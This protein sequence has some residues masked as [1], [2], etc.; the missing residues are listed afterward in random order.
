MEAT[1]KCKLTAPRVRGTGSVQRDA[2][3][4]PPVQP[5]VCGEQKMRS[6]DLVTRLGS[7][8]RVRGTAKAQTRY[9]VTVTVQPR[10]C[11]EQASVWGIRQF[12]FGSAPRVRG[13]VTPVNERIA[14][15]RFSPACA[16]NST[17]QPRKTV[18]K[19]VQPRV[20]G[21]QCPSPALREAVIGSAPRVRGTVDRQMP[22]LVGCR[23]SPACARNSGSHAETGCRAAVQ[24]RVCGEQFQFIRRVVVPFGSAPRVRGTDFRSGPVNGHWR[25]SPACA[26]NSRSGFISVA[27]ATVQPRVC[28][29]QASDMWDGL[30][31][32]GS[33]PRVRGTE[34]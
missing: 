20:C 25:F 2:G 14:A 34:G 3:R 27:L 31:K 24:P 15:A 29:E 1:T 8:P 28:G 6:I 5:R 11:G 12:Q 9:R 22:R 30:K 26:G 7:A 18:M 13:T 16:G 33:A 17:N 21:E 4:L 10:V 19:T 32:T 23:F